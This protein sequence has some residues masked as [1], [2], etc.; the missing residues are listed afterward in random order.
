VA[1]AAN[2]P[3]RVTN[4]WH[5]AFPFRPFSRQRKETGTVEKE[6]DEPAE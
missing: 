3:R 1:K 6:D 2:S 4:T 5:Q